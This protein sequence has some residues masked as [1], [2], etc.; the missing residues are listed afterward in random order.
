MDIR[1]GG[2]L[3]CVGETV[4]VKVGSRIA[5]MPRIEPVL[6]LNTVIQPII[7]GICILWICTIEI[8]LLAVR[9]AIAVTVGLQRISAPQIDLLTVSEPIAIAVRIQGVGTVQIDLITV[10]DTVTVTIGAEGNGGDS[11]VDKSRVA[12]ETAVS[13]YDEVDR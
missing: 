4:T 12:E 6:Y 11:C 5:T 9:Q 7:I 10:T 3:L 8:D 2:D 13:P 1:P